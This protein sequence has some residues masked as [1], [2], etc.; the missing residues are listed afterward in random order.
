[1][2]LPPPHNP[3]T[4]S[5]AF[6]AVSIARARAR[7]LSPDNLLLASSTLPRRRAVRYCSVIRRFVKR[8]DEICAEEHYNLIERPRETNL[9]TRLTEVKG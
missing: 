3:P 5:S 7:A 1:M 9:I 8:H 2:R 4:S 6:S